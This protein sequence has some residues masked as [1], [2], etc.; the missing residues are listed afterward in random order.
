MNKE[1]KD[2]VVTAL[3]SI[4]DSLSRLLEIVEEQR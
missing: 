4:A 3:N 2:Q 1:Q